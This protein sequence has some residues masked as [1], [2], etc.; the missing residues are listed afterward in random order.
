M[1]SFEEGTVEYGE[2]RPLFQKNVNIL[3]KN[4]PFFSKSRTCRL[5]KNRPFLREIQ[6]DDAYLLTTGVAG[7]GNRYKTSLQRF[8]FLSML[9]LYFGS[10]ND[11][12]VPMTQRAAKHA[13]KKGKV[14]RQD[15]TIQRI[16]RRRCIYFCQQPISRVPPLFCGQ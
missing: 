3:A 13:H 7:P 9:S 8:S 14:G 4:G 1:P 11:G 6:N 5:L 2:N 10:I 15:R 16:D 12:S